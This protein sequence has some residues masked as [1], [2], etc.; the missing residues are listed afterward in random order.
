MGC[1]G[2]W[3]C[4]GAATT[5]EGGAALRGAIMSTMG[6]SLPLEPVVSEVIH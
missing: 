2:V 5:A 4:C 1:S 6:Y 3:F